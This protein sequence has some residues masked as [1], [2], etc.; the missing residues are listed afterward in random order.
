[1]E[2][3]SHLATYYREELGVHLLPYLRDDNDYGQLIE[4]IS[5]FAKQ[6]PANNPIRIQERSELEALIDG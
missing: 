4:V 3:A 1:M 5:E 6:I 2:V